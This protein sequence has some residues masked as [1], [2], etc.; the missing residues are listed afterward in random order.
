[1]FALSPPEEK[2]AQAHNEYGRTIEEILSKEG[3][4][5]IYNILGAIEVLVAVKL[6]KSQATSA[7]ERMVFAL[8]WLAREV[9]TGGF[10]QFFT[11]TAGDFWRDALTGLRILG[12]HEGHRRFQEILSIFPNSAPS[13]ER[14]TRLQEIREL[15]SASASEFQ[16]HFYRSDEQYFRQS[17]PDWERVY[18]YVKANPSEFDLREV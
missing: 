2:I 18:G 11:N 15:E 5:D 17:F 13:A 1:M 6:S 10:Y 16:K 4:R 12:D 3:E 8:T 7:G 9:G 14:R